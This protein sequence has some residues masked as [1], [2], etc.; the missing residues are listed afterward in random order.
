MSIC[1]K[2]LPGDTWQVILHKIKE[3]FEIW[4]AFWLNPAG[5]LVLVKYVLSSLPIFQ[6]SSLLAP[7]GIKKYLAEEIH[8]FLWQGG[9]Y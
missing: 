6:F 2:S 3:K 7:V 4:G 8:K 5:R 1:L 9:K